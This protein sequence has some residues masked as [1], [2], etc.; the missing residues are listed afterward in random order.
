MVIQL[1]VG[2]PLL[3]LPESFPGLG[4]Y[5]EAMQE[6]L[7]SIEVI[8]R[9]LCVRIHILW[10]LT[11]PFDLHVAELVC[12]LLPLLLVELRHHLRGLDVDDLH[13]P[14][15]HLGPDL[16][17]V[18]ITQVDEHLDHHMLTLLPVPKLVHEVDQ[19]VLLHSAIIHVR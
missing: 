11:I 10:W 18:V 16:L 14:A 17:V 3:R 6:E 7:L 4:K 8:F 1:H 5:A 9:A 2:F 12:L 15:E 19:D 13:V